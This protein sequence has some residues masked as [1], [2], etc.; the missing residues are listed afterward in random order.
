MWGRRDLAGGGNITVMTDAP[1]PLSDQAIREALSDL[2]GWRYE[3]DALVRALT[4][5]S[6]REAMSFL[7]RMSFEA[8][9]L[10]HHPHITNV[11]NRVT[12]RLNTHDADDHVTQRDVDL[13]RRVHSFNWR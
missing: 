4:F 2:D 11:Y 1:A 12:L 13:A 5:G 7:V 3:E 10:N 9:E 6:F 8:E